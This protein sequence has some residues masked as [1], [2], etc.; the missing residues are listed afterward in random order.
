MTEERTERVEK[1]LASLTVSSA[2]PLGVLDRGKER[3]WRR[4]EEWK[5]C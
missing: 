1:N 4:S 5:N 2:I 3:W